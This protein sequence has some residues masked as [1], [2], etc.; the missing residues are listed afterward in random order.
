MFILGLFSFFL[1]L[2]YTFFMIRKTCDYFW[3]L[4]HQFVKY[5]VVGV[6]GLVIDLST[7]IFFTTVFGWTPVFA[8]I[9]NQSIVLGY[10]FTLNKYWSFRNTAI[11]HTQLVRYF[12]L[13]ACNYGISVLLMYIFH[14]LLSYD[15]RLVRIGT[16]ALMVS[17]NFF[18]Y[19]YWVY[20]DTEI[21]IS[22]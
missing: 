3:S 10:N 7:L 14:D 15:Y 17:W 16:I 18:L 6:S 19:K 9:V 22:A 4:R 11:P 8:V 2:C 21:E 5:V 1:F 20:K 13:A 12:I